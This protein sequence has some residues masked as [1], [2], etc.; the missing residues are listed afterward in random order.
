MAD[1]LSELGLRRL[2][3]AEAAQ[4][5]RIEM[6]INRKVLDI[7]HHNDVESWS[8]VKNAGIVGIIHKAT[9][10]TSYT[11]DQYLKRAGPALNAGLLW[12]AYHFANGSNVEAQVDHFLSVVGI[13]DE[14]LYALDWEDDPGGNTMSREQAREFLE[15]VEQRTG[16]KAVVYSGNTAKEKLGDD[17][18]EFFGEHRL[19]LAHYSSSPV[20]QDSWDE[21]WLHQYSD[22]SAGPGP[23]GCPGVTGDVDTNSWDGTDQELRQEWA[24]VSERPRPP[25]EDVPVVKMMIESDK[26]VRFRITLGGEAEIDLASIDD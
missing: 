24:G 10:G 2:G 9:E 20:P 14:T 17:E 18:D 23:H 19:W 11:D 21:I 3:G 1:R 4:S 12:G 13:D 16:R 8:A 25:V 15:L 7:S 6:T 5:G 22:G 26:P